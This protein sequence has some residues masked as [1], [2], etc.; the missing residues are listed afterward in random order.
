MP[1]PVSAT[2]FGLPGRS[3]TIVRVAAA[4]PWTAGRKRTWIEQ[5]CP[6]RRAAPVHVSLVLMNRSMSVPVI[7]AA[8]TWIAPSPAYVSTIG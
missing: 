6:I 5:L 8:D 2:L 3:L 4:A 1:F 7:D